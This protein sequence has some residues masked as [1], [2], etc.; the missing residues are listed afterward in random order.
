MKESSPSRRIVEKF[1]FGR[2]ATARKAHPHNVEQQMRR[3]TIVDEN[4]ITKARFHPKDWLTEDQIRYLFAKMASEVRKGESPETEK[5]LQGIETIPDEG[6]EAEAQ[7]IIDDEDENFY[8]AAAEN[9]TIFQVAEDAL[10]DNE[11]GHP[12]MVSFN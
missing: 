5:L 6:P 9:M 7:Q 11:R 3:E 8:D 2:Q 12:L 10:M 4:G 1:E